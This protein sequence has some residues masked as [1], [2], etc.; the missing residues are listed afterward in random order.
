MKPFRPP[1]KP[2]VNYRVKGKF[3]DIRRERKKDFRA[4]KRSAFDWR[5]HMRF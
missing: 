1:N 2:A 5:F 4:K 3:E